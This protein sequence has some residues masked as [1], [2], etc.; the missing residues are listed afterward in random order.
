MSFEG[1]DLK[2]LDDRWFRP[3]A[4]GDLPVAEQFAAGYAAKVEGGK[5]R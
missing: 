3:V 1:V 4:S 2:D 5:V